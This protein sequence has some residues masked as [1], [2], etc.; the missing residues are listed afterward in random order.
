MQLKFSGPKNNKRFYDHMAHQAFC[1]LCDKNGIT[2]DNRLAYA[3]K[4]G[5][6]FGYKYMCELE[7]A[8][9]S[10]EVLYYLQNADGN[11]KRFDTELETTSRIVWEH[12]GEV[13]SAYLVQREGQVDC[14]PSPEYADAFTVYLKSKHHSRYYDSF[15]EEWVEKDEEEISGA[16]SL[17]FNYF[18]G[19]Y[20]QHVETTSSTA[21]SDKLTN[22]V[23][24]Q[25]LWKIEHKKELKY[26][27][28]YYTPDGPREYEELS[29]KK[30]AL[31]KEYERAKQK[32]SKTNI[33]IF[34]KCII[35]APTVITLIIAALAVYWSFTGTQNLEEAANKGM[36]LSWLN[37]ASQ[38]D[39]FLKIITFIPAIF[40]KI[41]AV[42]WYI[43]ALIGSIIRMEKIIVVLTM[44][45]LVAGGY[46]A[47]T[48]VEESVVRSRTDVIIT[49]KEWKA[50][51][52]AKKDAEEIGNLPRFKELESNYHKIMQEYME[53]SNRWQK[54]WF[55]AC[56]DQK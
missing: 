43:I 26:R 56:M 8:I 25:S 2:P 37:Q 29:Q 35:A 15:N 45:M 50:A 46:V 49:R 17:P 44:L 21:G 19:E 14:W 34:K 52:K 1:A 54:A 33:N 22:V 36:I 53:F 42:L 24:K 32:K 47:S 13:M 6:G 27:G 5:V 16:V 39:G 41:A 38:G 30:H 3:E 12:L 51:L 20:T 4:M 28:A 55:K 9:D 7:Q 48:I 31:E 11:H 23:R 10:N 18:G 40:V